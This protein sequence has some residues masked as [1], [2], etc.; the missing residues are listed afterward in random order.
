MVR[1]DLVDV[2]SARIEALDQAPQALDVRGSA[3]RIALGVV[4]SEHDET[5]RNPSRGWR[6]G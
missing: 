6:G 5:V 4:R 1:G 3:H 2:I